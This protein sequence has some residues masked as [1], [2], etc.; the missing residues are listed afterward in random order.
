MFLSNIDDL[1][2]LLVNGLELGKSRDFPDEIYVTSD[3][4]FPL[5]Y[6]TPNDD[7]IAHLPVLIKIPATLSLQRYAPEVFE[8]QNREVF[9]RNVPAHF[10]SDI[11]GFLAVNGKP[12][13]YK[14][15]LENDALVFIPASG[16]FR[17]WSAGVKKEKK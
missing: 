5:V 1:K 13:W 6:A 14:V 12:D 4:L 7:E 11:W 2:N 9:M 3:A 16:Q 10:I 15:V 17:P 8:D